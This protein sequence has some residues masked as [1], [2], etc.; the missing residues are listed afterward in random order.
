MDHQPTVKV[1]VDQAIFT[2]IRSPMGE[3][4]R[5]IAH[6]PGV[7]NEERMEITRNCPS[8]GGLCGESAAD[9]GMMSYRL[10][11]ERYC[12][13]YSCNAGPEHTGRGGQRIYTHLVLLDRTAFRLFR[14]DPVRIHAA[15]GKAIGGAPMLNPPNRLNT[16]ELRVEEP[17]LTPPFQMDH[18]CHIISSVLS[19][20]RMVVAGLPKP[21][22][23]FQ[24]LLMAVPIS[25][26]E[27]LSVSIGMKFSIVRHTQLAFVD[28]DPGDI[29]RTIRG[30]DIELFD[31]ETPV[32]KVSWPLNGWMDVVRRRWREGRFSEISQLSDRL[33]MNAKGTDL[34]RIACICNDMDQIKD[35]DAAQLEQIIIKYDAFS[36]SNEAES[37]LVRDLNSAARTRAFFLQKAEEPIRNDADSL[38]T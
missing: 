8:H 34:D 13:A 24:W 17:V 9:L 31:M 35:S 22:E 12:I 16:L 2:S 27:S 19:R 20:R 38:D 29:R 3:G 28:R 7:S 10:A 11:S 26:R 1:S 18:V 14:C 6:S 4:Y 15:I 23:A 32:P 25:I 5:L 33:F 37:L 30:H 21:L 36:P